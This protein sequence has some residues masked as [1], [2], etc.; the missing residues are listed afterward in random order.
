MRRQISLFLF[1]IALLAV[2]PAAAQESAPTTWVPIGGFYPDTFPGFIDAALPNIERFETDRLY[3]LMMPMSF[4]YDPYVLTSADLIVNTQDSER[5]RRQLE[6]ACRDIVPAEIY[7]EVVVPPI[8]TREAADAPEVLDYFADDLA[9]VYFMGG[10]QVYAMQITAGTGLEAALSDAFA[11]GVVM[12]GNSAG[13]A[14]ESRAM[15]AGYGGDAFGPENALL[16]G[17]VDIWN[18]TDDAGLERGLDFGITNAMLEQHFWERARFAR[19]LN[20][21]VQEGAPHVGIGVDSFTGAL[22]T[23]NTTLEA[24]FGLYTGAILDAETLGAVESASFS[25]DAEVL[26]VRNVLLHTFAVGDYSYDLN[27][28]QPSTTPALESVTRA[29]DGLTLPEGAGTLILYGSLPADDVI[30]ALEERTAVIIAA[31]DTLE[32]MTSIADQFAGTE[33]AV[34][35][36]GDDGRVPDLTPYDRIVVYSG[37]ASSIDVETLRAPLQD[38]W[39]SGKTLVLDDAAAAII[40][41][42]Y[43]AMPPTPYDSED[44]LLIEAAT[45]GTLLEGGVTLAA[46]LGFLPINIE[47][48]VMADNRW[49]RMIALAYANPDTITVGLPDDAI[50][51]ISSDGATVGGTNAVITLDLRSATLGLGDNSGY[52]ITNGLLDVFA[53]GDS[54]TPA[55]AG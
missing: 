50:L 14:L 48:R 11:R 13:L 12:G 5:R 31:F 18:A 22:I 55:D 33:A 36:L 8:Y 25:N 3:I 40:G 46:G 51:I 7:C 30:A 19:L 38:A 54:V 34:F 9:G 29:F 44:D 37:D 26:S 10:D 45:Q 2:M 17:A 6:D 4:T 23:N 24:P 1:V 52:V 27:T 20:A 32:A 47:T 15:I 16:Q 49:G 42:Q 53:P 21:I 28:R 43:S 35:T 39:L 41:Q